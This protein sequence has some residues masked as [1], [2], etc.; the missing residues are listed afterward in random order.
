MVD[1]A[2]TEYIENSNC[3]VKFLNCPQR[4]YNIASHGDEVN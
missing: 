1:L 4:L 3:L 2:D